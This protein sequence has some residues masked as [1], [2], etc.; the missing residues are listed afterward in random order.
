MQPH[1]ELLQKLPL[2]LGKNSIKFEME[3][4]SLQA[5]IYLYSCNDKLLISDFDGTATKS[6]VRGFIHN[7]KGKDYL[8]EGYA[9]LLCRAD[10]QGYKVVWLTMRSLPLYS[11][12]KE[13][14]R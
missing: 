7:F 9:E 3:N 4:T 6:D 13:C 5:E 10:R 11:F 1:S 12:S 2:R 8:H 14:A